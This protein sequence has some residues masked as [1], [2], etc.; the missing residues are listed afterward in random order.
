MLS[1]PATEHE[2]HALIMPHVDRLPAIAEMVTEGAPEAYRA[3]FEEEYRFIVGQLLPHLEKIEETLYPEL[4]RLMQNRHS[5]VPMRHEHQ[6]VHRLVGS[7][8][9]YRTDLAAGR[10]GAAEAIGLRRVLFRLYAIL[11]VHFAEEEHHL[12]VLEG[13]LSRE[14]RSALA[15]EMDHAMAEPL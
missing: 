10:L 12:N 7:L 14:E 4:E 13:N 15:H 3:A 5:M 9:K 2:H 6:Q 8:G 11:K 1:L